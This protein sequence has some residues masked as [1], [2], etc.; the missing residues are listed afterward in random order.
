MPTLVESDGIGFSF[1]QEIRMNHSI[2]MLRAMTKLPNSGL[3]LL[4]YKKV[5]EGLTG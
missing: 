2:S 4:G 3:N 1:M 5:V